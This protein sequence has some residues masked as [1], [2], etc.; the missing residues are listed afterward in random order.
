MLHF[1]HT[2]LASRMQLSFYISFTTK[3]YII[4][5]AGQFPNEIVYIFKL[6]FET[7]REGKMFKFQTTDALVPI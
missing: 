4:C 2:K 5:T 1:T 6:F 7:I 3:Q